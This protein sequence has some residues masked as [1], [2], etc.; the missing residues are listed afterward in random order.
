MARSRRPNTTRDRARQRDHLSIPTALDFDLDFEPVLPPKTVTPS[1]SINLRDPVADLLSVEDR[2]TWH[3]EGPH[4]PARSS[5]RWNA[6]VN[7]LPP[8][9]TRRAFLR[10]PRLTPARPGHARKGVARPSLF[11][12]LLRFRFNAPKY[13]AVCVRRSIRRQ[14]LFATRRTGRGARAPRRRNYQSSV[15]CR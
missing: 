1:L 9:R 8:Q 10:G 14:V 13:V 11:S 15:Y 6:R 4:R 5:R 3:P 12:Q 2:R 7:L